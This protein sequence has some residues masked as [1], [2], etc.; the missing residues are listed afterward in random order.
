M[1]RDALGFIAWARE[2]IGEVRDTKGT[3][4]TDELWDQL[5]LLEKS[6]RAAEA[7]RMKMQRGVSPCE[8]NGK[9]CHYSR[10]PHSGQYIDRYHS[11]CSVCGWTR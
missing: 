9:A 2:F 1:N 6:F 11:E 7:R 4:M 5:N 8:Q 10:S 3:L